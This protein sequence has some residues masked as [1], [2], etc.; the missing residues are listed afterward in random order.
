MNAEWT[1]LFAKKSKPKAK[2]KGDQQ[3]SKV[4]GSDDDEINVGKHEH[5]LRFAS[6]KKGHAEYKD[7]QKIIK[8]C[9]WND[10]DKCVECDYGKLW[11]FSRNKKID[12]RITLIQTMH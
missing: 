11:K 9:K 4:D 6:F 8:K 1:G 3:N 12:I 7:S 10:D 5:W 2:P